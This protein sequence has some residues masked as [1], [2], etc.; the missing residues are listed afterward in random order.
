[1]DKKAKVMIAYCLACQANTP[2]THSE[3]LQMSRL[4]ENTWQEVSADF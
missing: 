1:M 3:L 2:V 4:P